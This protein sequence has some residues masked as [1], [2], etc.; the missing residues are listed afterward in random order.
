MTG[1]SDTEGTAQRTGHVGVEQELTVLLR[2][3][4]G[5]SQ[6]FARQI[7]PEL[8]NDA[9]GLLIRL[10]QVDG[11]RGTD[12]AAFFGVG[13]PTI[14]RQV[15]T[16]EKLGLVER[17]PD[18]TDGRATV[19]KITEDGR[20]RIRRMREARREYFGELLA[21]WDEADVNL[22]A[23]LLHRYNETVFSYR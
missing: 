2:R 17:H 15:A 21:S 13:K 9:Y 7:H 4:R 6:E 23:K 11:A 14:S 18:E 10:D 20:A 5:T 8:E 19:L 12:L 22:F 16:L 3:A 1:A